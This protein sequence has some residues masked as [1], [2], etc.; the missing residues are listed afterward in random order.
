MPRRQG[1]SE[2]YLHEFVRCSLRIVEYPGPS[3]VPGPPNPQYK[4]AEALVDWL[5]RVCF[6]SGIPDLA[7]IRTEYEALVRA[8]SLRCNSR[9]TVKLAKTLSDVVLK[10]RTVMPASPYELTHHGNSIRGS[11]AILAD[12]KKEDHLFIPVIAMEKNRPPEIEF[13]ARWLHL[14]HQEPLATVKVLRIGING[15]FTKTE[16]YNEKYVLKYLESILDNFAQKRW[17]PSP[18]EHCQNCETTSCKKVIDGPNDH[19]IPWLEKIS[20]PD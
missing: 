2:S 14:R 6:Q 18:G 17:F 8:N 3:Y 4:A 12:S 15:D 10:Y 11:Y 20:I 5:T 9:Q 13:M 1:L 7:A 19:R 16:T